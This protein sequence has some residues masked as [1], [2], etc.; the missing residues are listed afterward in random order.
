MKPLLIIFALLAGSLPGIL[1]SQ[2]K[3]PQSPRTIEPIVGVV[4]TV[5]YHGVSFSF[6][7][8]LTE[9]VTPL[10]IP[11]ST[12]GKPSD[13]WPDH[14]G[15][16]LARYPRPRS[17]PPED[18]HIRVFS[19]PK[20]REALA[21]A[22][23]EYKKSMAQSS[24]VEDWTIYLDTEVGL[25]KSLL[26][27]KPQGANLRNLLSRTRG[28]KGC[29]GTMPFLPLWEACQAFVAR[30]QYVKFKNGEGVLFLTQQN[31]SET[32]QVTNQGLE[33]AFQ[34]VTDDGQSY[35]YAEFSV[36]APF[37]PKGEEPAVEA[38]DRKNYLLS[39]KSAK[40]QQHVRPIVAKLETLPANQF[41]PN[42]ELLENLIGSLDVR[43]K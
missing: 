18:P 21:T 16:A 17:L 36:T 22:T 8:A 30:A 11:A 15:F 4:Q 20:F 31:V 24:K 3:R 43:L 38:W 7:R 23:V 28:S 34:G 29:G 33:Y 25:L 14:V 2:T 13:I 27:S 35:V 37:L 39:N 41:K 1:G 5:S 12:E 32:S 9:G 26:K 10:T 42:L 6:D 19:I 40:Y